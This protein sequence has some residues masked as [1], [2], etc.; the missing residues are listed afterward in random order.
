MALTA[1]ARRITGRLAAEWRAT[2]ASV[3]ELEAEIPYPLT[4]VVADI[5]AAL[6]RRS[7]HDRIA[8]TRVVRDDV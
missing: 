4:R 6:A 5:E 1:K 3:L 8:G 7:W 2:E